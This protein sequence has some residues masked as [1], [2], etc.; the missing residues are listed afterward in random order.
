MSQL[1]KDRYCM[2]LLAWGAIIVKFIERSWW[3]P[4]LRGGWNGEMLVKG[5]KH[6]HITQIS[7]GDLM[8]SMKV[9]MNV[10]QS[11][12]TLC[13]PMDCSSWNSPGQNT[14][15]GNLSFLQGIF[16]TQG[17]NSGLPHCRQ[18]L[19]QLSHKGTPRILEWVSYPFS[20]RSSQS[21]NWTRVSC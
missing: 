9:K 18:I 21:R 7:S 16:P 6:S 20:S 13:D 12:M 8:N 15:V 4:G 11:C 2:N 19:H 3:W 1:Q 17:L 5:Y 14:G 10:S